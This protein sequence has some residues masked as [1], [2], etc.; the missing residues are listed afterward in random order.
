MR[1]ASRMCGRLVDTGDMTLT[2]FS[3]YQ[4]LPLFAFGTENFVIVPI[5]SLSKFLVP[6][7]PGV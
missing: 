6:K 1:A 5:I 2:D 3:E 7:L 4:S